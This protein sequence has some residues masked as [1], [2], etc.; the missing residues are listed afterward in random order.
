VTAALAGFRS[1][2]RE[3][4]DSIDLA[5]AAAAALAGLPVWRSAECTC[6]GRGFHSYRRDRTRRRQVALA[7][8][9]SA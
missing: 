7:W 4:A 5:A 3:G 8:L 1:T 9:P 6:C 2:T